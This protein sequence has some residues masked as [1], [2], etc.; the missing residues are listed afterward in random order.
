MKSRPSEESSGLHSLPTLCWAPCVTGRV[1]LGWAG[2]IADPS[3]KSAGS[4]SSVLSDSTLRV[5][6]TRSQAWFTPVAV[7]Q[8]NGDVLRFHMHSGSICT[9]VP[10]VLSD[11]NQRRAPRPPRGSH[12]SDPGGGAGRW[13]CIWGPPVLSH[14]TNGGLP[15]PPGGSRHFDPSGGA[16]RWR[17]IPGPRGGWCGTR[18]P[19][20]M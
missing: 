2:R 19:P 12:H 4:P 13:R 15:Q 11:H 7:A 20:P 8:G 17:C 18:R 1:R 16:G 14:S 3:G 9:Q 5:T 10:Y 6:S